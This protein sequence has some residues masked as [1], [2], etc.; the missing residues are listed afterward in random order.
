MTMSRKTLIA[1]VIVVAVLVVA[2]IGAYTLLSAPTG[3]VSIYIKDAPADWKHV[4]VTFSEVN[5]HQ[6]GAANDSG[7]QT[8]SIKNGTMDLVSLTNVS[9]LLASANVSV[10]KYTQIRFVVTSVTGVMVNGTSVVFT[11]PSG[12]L[13]TNHPFNVT[14]DD[15][16][17]L[18][19]DID[20]SN[21]IVYSNG[22]WKFTPVIGAVTET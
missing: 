2:T 9:E 20:L 22:G 19:L 4:N 17:T 7:W 10:G 16:K 1:A 21:S 11:V 8:L 6:A 14:S 13:K 5:I 3:T 18:T 12:E 15:T